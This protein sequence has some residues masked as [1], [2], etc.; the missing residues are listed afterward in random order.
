MYLVQFYREICVYMC[1]T[2]KQTFFVVASQISWNRTELR[3][4]DISRRIK[5]YKPYSSTC[6]LAFYLITNL[7]LYFFTS[8][9]PLHL[10]VF[11]YLVT[12]YTGTYLSY[13]PLSFHLTIALHWY[14]YMH[15][16]CDLSILS[17]YT[18]SSCTEWCRCGFPQYYGWEI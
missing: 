10:F 12:L 6:I 5:S 18:T 17:I 1:C 16:Y 14:V 2:R 8:I 4:L 7:W 3:Q 11:I 13:T 9:P 15:S